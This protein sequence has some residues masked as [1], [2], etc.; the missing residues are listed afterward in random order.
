MKIKFTLIDY[1]IIVLVIC[2][3][4]FAF[5]H[6]TSDN[7]SDIQKTAFDESTVNKIPDTYSKYYR[8]GFIVKSTVEGINSTNGE[9]V[10][11]NGTVIWQ[12]NNGGGDVKL[13]IKTDNGTYSTGLYRYNSNS[14][15]YID[16]IS[17]E[18]N[19][20]KYNNLTEVNIKPLTINSLADLTSGIKNDTD[21]EL[22]TKVSLDSLEPKQ[23]QQISNILE[24]HGKRTS[25]ESDNTE[26]TITLTKA[27]KENI[28]DA[29]S[30]LGNNNGIT[31]QITIR[32]YNCTDD[33]I[34]TI[35]HNYEVMSVRNF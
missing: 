17:L 6:I 31:N 21:F 12:N 29:N 24:Q 25:I 16:H 28:N 4:I 14:D 32:I 34:N 1:L 18:S 5:I 20:E 22:T 9:K 23:I 35:K 27:T 30:I 3:V 11:L 33:Q 8:D 10:T 19:G 7:S 13:L 26:N 15:I 2:A